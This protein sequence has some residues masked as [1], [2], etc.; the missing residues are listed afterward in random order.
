[1]KKIIYTL[2]I[3]LAII[4]YKPLIA[5]GL[6]TRWSTDNPF[7]TNVFIKNV[8]QFDNYAKTPSTVKVVLRSE[9]VFFTSRA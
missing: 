4:N 2:L 6:K 3:V 1:M 9:N 7:K 8:G 5:Q